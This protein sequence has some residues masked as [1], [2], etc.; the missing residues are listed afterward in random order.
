MKTTSIA[1][2]GIVVLAAGCATAPNTTPEAQCQYFA[3]SE[4]L[5]WIRDVKSE[6]AG[7]GT[8]VT[9]ELKDSLG[10]RFN[11]TCVVAGGAPKW[12]SP[13]PTNTVTRQEGRDTMAP[14][15]PKK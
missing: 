2:A 8:G 4:G 1:L 5:E 12:A 10:R 6:P 15:P 14:P 9:M 13:L 7:G 11:H 3:R